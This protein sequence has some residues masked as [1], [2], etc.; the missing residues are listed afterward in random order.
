M[1]Q[2]ANITKAIMKQ[3][4]VSLE[5]PNAYASKAFAAMEQ[6]LSNGEAYVPHKKKG[7]SRFFSTVFGFG[8]RF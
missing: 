1:P 6:R 8:K 3:K 4:P 7:V 2:D 5:C